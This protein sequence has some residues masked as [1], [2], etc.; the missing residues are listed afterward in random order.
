MHLHRGRAGQ[1]GPVVYSLSAPVEDQ[2]LGQVALDPADEADL[3]TQGFYLD[4]HTDLFPDGELSGQVVPDPTPPPVSLARQ[5]QPL[6]KAGCSCHVNG[7]LAA[8]VSVDEGDTFA[9]LVS[10]PSGQSEL[11]LVEPGDP[12]K[13]YLIHKLRGTQ[14]R[15]GG[16]GNRMPPSAPLSKAKL[17]LIERWILQGAEDN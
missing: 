15:V 6:F 5:I 17:R 13:S 2:A 3:L 9:G 8:G 7:R 12:E 16:S 11:N 10:A 4:L 1:D 14:R